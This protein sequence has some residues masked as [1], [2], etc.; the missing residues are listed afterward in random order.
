M[1]PRPPPQTRHDHYFEVT[2]AGVT[3]TTYMLKAAN[4]EDMQNWV[5]QIQ[6]QV[7]KAQSPALDRTP[8]P[9]PRLTRDLVLVEHG[10]GRE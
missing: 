3:A 6:L 7:K 10:N 1:H 9:N 8:S 4:D 2:T 5:K